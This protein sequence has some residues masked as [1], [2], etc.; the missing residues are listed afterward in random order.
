VGGRRARGPASWTNPTQGDGPAR[1]RGSDYPRL[2][3]RGNPSRR[4]RQDGASRS[5]SVNV[6]SVSVYSPRVLRLPIQ[7][8]FAIDGLC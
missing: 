6:L 4:V 2:S 7:T 8:M 5:Q 1:S 3:V